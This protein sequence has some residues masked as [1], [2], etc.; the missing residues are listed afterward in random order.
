M[1]KKGFINHNLSGYISITTRADQIKLLY[2]VQ[3]MYTV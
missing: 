1:N 3:S 2:V